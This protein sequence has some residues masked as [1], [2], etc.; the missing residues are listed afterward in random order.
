L[1]IC[2]IY[3][4]VYILICNYCNFDLLLMHYSLSTELYLTVKSCVYDGGVDS[5]GKV[6]TYEVS[7]FLEHTKIA[8]F[9]S[10]MSVIRNIC[11]VTL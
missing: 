10:I 5:Q 2:L 11:S 8:F 4:F 1:H 3:T 6:I 7:L 9:S